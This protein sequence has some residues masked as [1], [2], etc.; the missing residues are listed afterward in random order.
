MRRPQ[1]SKKG[2]S[3]PEA[4][5]CVIGLCNRRIEVYKRSVSHPFGRLSHGIVQQFQL[6]TA[7]GDAQRA[8]VSA[9]IKRPQTH[10]MLAR[11]KRR[12]VDKIAFMSTV[13]N[14]VFREQRS[15]KRAVNAE[16]T[17]AYFAR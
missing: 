8:H 5:D 10:R 9:T 16:I 11:A 2:A 7:Q 4:V 6:L 3:S 17:L 13:G 1:S 14:P 12:E 15:P